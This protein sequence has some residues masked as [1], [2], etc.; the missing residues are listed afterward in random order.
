MTLSPVL[1]PESKFA[2]WIGDGGERK[3]EEGAARE[4]G[5]FRAN[6]MQNEN[7]AHATMGANWKSPWTNTVNLWLVPS[8]SLAKEELAGCL[9]D[10]ACGFVLKFN[11]L[12]CFQQINQPIP[13]NTAAIFGTKTGFSPGATSIDDGCGGNN[14]NNKR[15]E[16]CDEDT[17]LPRGTVSSIC[18]RFSWVFPGWVFHWATVHVLMP[19]DLE[20]YI[21]IS[22]KQN[23]QVMDQ[24]ATDTRVS[25]AENPNDVHDSFGK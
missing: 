6:S 7:V 1:T 4:R 23:S 24:S 8:S 15:G 18:A 17:R 20:Y 22:N 5:K 21:P 14:D 3:R 2:M 12:A 9:L 16:N 11:R 19:T 25:K 10:K 13:I